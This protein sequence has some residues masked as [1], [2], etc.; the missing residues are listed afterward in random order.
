MPNTIM[1]KIIKELDTSKLD[2]ISNRCLEG[3]KCDLND[4]IVIF[5][6]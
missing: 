5:K 2:R 6:T 4:L 3:S 1:M